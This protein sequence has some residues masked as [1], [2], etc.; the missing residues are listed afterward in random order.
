M[1]H[2]EDYYLTP[3]KKSLKVGSIAFYGSKMIVDHKVALLQ[4]FKSLKLNKK[5]ESYEHW[6]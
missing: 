5:W 1:E 6:K 4:H 2:L 3:Q